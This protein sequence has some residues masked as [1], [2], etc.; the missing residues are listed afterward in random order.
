MAEFGRLSQKKIL[1]ESSSVMTS[2]CGILFIKQ[3]ILLIETGLYF[4]FVTPFCVDHTHL[5][6][7]EDISS[8]FSRSSLKKTNKY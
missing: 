8:K 5:I 4:S 7:V 6:S 3:G 2:Q 1:I